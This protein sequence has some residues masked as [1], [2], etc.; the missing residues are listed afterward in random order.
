MDESAEERD[1]RQ[2]ANRRHR[3]FKAMEHERDFKITMGSKSGRATM[4]RILEECN[5]FS[6]II[7]EHSGMMYALAGKREIGL[8]IMSDIQRICPEMYQIMVNEHQQTDE[9]NDQ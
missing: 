4:W 9:V 6:S 8:M 2:A 5:V 3:M 1:E 7:N